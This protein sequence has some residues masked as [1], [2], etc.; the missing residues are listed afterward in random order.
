M[1]NRAL[2]TI[3][4]GSAER[5]PIRPEISAKFDRCAANI[6]VLELHFRKVMTPQTSGR[7][8]AAAVPPT[9]RIHIILFSFN[10][11]REAKRSF[12]LTGKF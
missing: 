5:F 12:R 8:A 10:V 2:R 9:D 1:H 7:L 3:S 11:L 6:A 4:C